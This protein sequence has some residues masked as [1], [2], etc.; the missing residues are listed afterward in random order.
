M[1]SICR[2]LCCSFAISI[3]LAACAG[4]E[5]PSPSPSVSTDS[6]STDAKAGK[7]ANVTAPAAAAQQ[8]ALILTSQPGWVVEQPT[9][10]MRR[11]QYLLPRA[12]G[13]S[14]DASLIIYYF[15]PKAGT[16]EANLERWAGQFTQPDGSSSADAMRTSTRTIAG[17]SVVDADLSGDYVAETT[18]GSGVRVNK[19]DM[20]MLAS[21]VEASDGPWYFKLV[22]PTASVSKWEAS[23]DSFVKAIRPGQ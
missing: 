20:R 19:K 16:T 7:Q 11:A 6:S 2:H 9:S 17:L 4:Q 5:Q 12:D 8:P 22:G 13:D 15:G 21:I 18:P 10:N 14:E 23:Y 3:S 1:L